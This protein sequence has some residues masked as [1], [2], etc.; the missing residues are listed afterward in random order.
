MSF[1]R[2]AP[3]CILAVLVTSCGGGTT[4]GNGPGSGSLPGH[5]APTPAPGKSSTPAPGSSSTPAPGSSSTPAP[6][7]STTPTPGPGPST[8]PIA[9]NVC[10]GTTAPAP[11]IPF[12]AAT[13]SDPFYGQPNPFPKSA[14]GTILASRSVT[15][16]PDSTTMTNSA[17]Q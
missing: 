5:G 8:S 17:W 2:T 1:W 3:V 12:P 13:D 7:S 10:G 16:E 4:I 9:S 6:G 14:P 11:A 15:Y